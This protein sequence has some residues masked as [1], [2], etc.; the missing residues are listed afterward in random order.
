[1]RLLMRADTATRA[2]CAFG[3]IEHEVVRLDIA[4]DEAVRRRS[5]TPFKARSH[6]AFVAPLTT[7]NSHQSIAD[8]KRARMPAL[9]CFS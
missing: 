3:I 7:F 9:I 5:I 6:S 1:M 8:Q 2:A 4:I